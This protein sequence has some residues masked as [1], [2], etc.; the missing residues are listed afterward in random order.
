MA[1]LRIAAF[2]DLVG[3]T[4]LL[5]VYVCKSRRPR[6]LTSCCLGETV[7]VRMDQNPGP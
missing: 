7:V 3:R 1:G 2:G 4:D 5:E 6:R